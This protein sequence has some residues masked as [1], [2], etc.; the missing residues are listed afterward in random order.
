MKKAYTWVF[1]ALLATYIVLAFILPTNPETLS[2]YGLT[3]LSARLLNLTVVVPIA[4]IYLSALYGFIHVDNYANKILYS[5]EGPHFKKLA[6]GLAILAF[7]LPVSSIIGSLRSYA[8]H[9]LPDLAP[10]VTILRNYVILAFV[11]VAMLFIAKGAQ[12]LYHTLGRRTTNGNGQQLSLY[13]VLGP[14]LLAS[15]YTW[16]VIAQGNRIPGDEPYYLPEW[17]LVTTFVIPYVFVWCVGIWAAIHLRKYQDAV[18]GVVYKRAINH[19]AFGIAVIILVSILVQSLGSL[20]VVLSRLDLT[21]VLA[22]VYFLIA[23]YVVGY[24]LV[25]RG[26]K[27]LKQIEEA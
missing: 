2:K 9:S 11:C 4:L 17:V 20:S 13:G 12:G 8:R 18:K 7:S 16:L 24:G 27:Q 22:L 1:L 10:S 19:I 14:V 6:A 21:P 15:V 26:A 5:K 23:L 3:E 25:A